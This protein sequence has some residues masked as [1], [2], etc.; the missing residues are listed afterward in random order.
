MI[1]S[2][3]QLHQQSGEPISNNLGQSWTSDTARKQAPAKADW[4]A[5]GIDT[6]VDCYQ[7]DVAIKWWQKMSFEMVRV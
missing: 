6:H 1:Y 4:T 5:F 2:H 7:I 3:V